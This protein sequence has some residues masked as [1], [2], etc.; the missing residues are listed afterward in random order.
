MV[1]EMLKAFVVVEAKL[2]E[3][4]RQRS[5]RSSE[6]K[7]IQEEAKEVQGGLKALRSRLHLAMALIERKAGNFD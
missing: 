1:T 6:S 4:K 3:L 2:P 7:S 5:S